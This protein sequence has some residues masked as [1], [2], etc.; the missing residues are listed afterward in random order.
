MDKLTKNIELQLW[1]FGQNTRTLQESRQEIAS[2]WEDNASRELNSRFF[3]PH[4]NDSEK[5]IRFF[6][7]QVD[8]VKQ[9]ENE[10]VIIETAVEEANKLSGEIDSSLQYSRADIKQ[11]YHTLDECIYSKN[12]SL[13]YCKNT[14]DKLDKLAKLK[15]LHNSGK[16]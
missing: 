1:D 2:G 13:D 14:Q 5:S 3:N 6:H 15:Q 11:A 7:D 10:F 12:Q 4:E 8:N 16:Y 9:M